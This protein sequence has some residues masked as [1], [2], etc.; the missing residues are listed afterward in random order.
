M[1]E[2]D[3]KK[4]DL[5]RHLGSIV[6]LLSTHIILLGKIKY[7]S[8]STILLPMTEIFYTNFAQNLKRLKDVPA[9][10]T[11]DLYPPNFCVHD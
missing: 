6:S 7:G 4:S 5:N 9:N 3:E 11:T 8:T 10:D 2:T 1:Q